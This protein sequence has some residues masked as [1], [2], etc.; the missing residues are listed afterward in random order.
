MH[1]A[2]WSAGTSLLYTGAV[3]TLVTVVQGMYRERGESSNS[4][5]RVAAA[6][7]QQLRRLS[8]PLTERPARPPSWPAIS[9]S[10]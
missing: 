7:E 3:F 8:Y 1:D 4:A 10:R 9:G 6:A 2:L 5:G